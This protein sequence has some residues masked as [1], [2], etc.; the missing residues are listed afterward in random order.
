MH[1]LSKGTARIKKE[2]ERSKEEHEYWMSKKQKKLQ[3][4]ANKAKQKQLIRDWKEWWHN[5]RH[6]QVVRPRL[7]PMTSYF[8]RHQYQ[9]GSCHQAGSILPLGKLFI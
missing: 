6:G 3:K 9:V 7:M 2:M 1:D 4:M 8:I 5:E